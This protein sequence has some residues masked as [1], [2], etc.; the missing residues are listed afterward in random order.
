MDLK[1]H[2]NATT[3]P[4]TRAYIQ[5]ST[6]RA[7]ALAAELG[8]SETTIRRWR[9]RSETADRSHTPHRLAISLSPVE[10]VLVIELRVEVGL[11]LDDIVEVMRR[12][13]NPQLS[14]SAI[15]R[16]LRRH[17]V[18][19]RPAPE[20]AP[21]GRF[22]TVPV[23]FIHVD[24]KHLTRLDGQPAFVF[25]AI[26]R[27]TRFVHIEIMPRRDADTAA[28]CLERFLDAFPHPVQTIVTDNGSEFTDRF[29]GARWG[30][31]ASGTG[32]HAFDR[33]CARHGIEHRLTKPFRPQT[34]GMVER[35][36][37]R[38]AEAVRARPHTG[39]N[40][41]RNTFSSHAER[42]AFLHAFVADY[43]R[44][45]LKCLGY[46]SPARA[47]ANQTGLNTFAGMTAPLVRGRSSRRRR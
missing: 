47:L 5:A 6:A 25:V 28:A 1:L 23:G 36:N 14:R 38:L 41:G 45:R 32:R 11:S 4:R 22:E 21:V 42:D 24:L 31:R 34:N 40:G 13:V 9:A 12:C 19:R 39:G 30:K 8:V 16:A 29:G 46:I 3:T 2:A 35:F 33:I 17:G 15:H 18:S 27:A 37:R 10:E 7:A 20:K 26:D 43:N 44:T